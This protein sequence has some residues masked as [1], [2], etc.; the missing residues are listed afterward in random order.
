MMKNSSTRLEK[1]SEAAHRTIT[2]FN[3]SPGVPDFLTNAM[4]FALD[5]AAKIKGIRIYKKLEDN[6]EDFD[7]EGLAQL[8]AASAFLSLKN[9]ATHGDGEATQLSATDR[10]RIARAVAD[11]L[12]IKGVPASLFN[13]VADFITEGT[14]DTISKLWTAPLIAGLID[15]VNEREREGEEVSHAN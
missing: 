6:S 5:E 1:Y 13:K 12:T 4:M 14:S 15:R 8:F 7:A 10:D 3:G 9:E 2:L 11:I